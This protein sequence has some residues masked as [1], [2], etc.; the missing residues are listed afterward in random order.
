MHHA[1]AIIH[2][3]NRLNVYLGPPRPNV[4]VQLGGSDPVAMAT[5]ARIIADNGYHEVNIN[6]GCPSQRVQHGHFGAIL[7][8]TPDLVAEILSTI[9]V[10][11]PVTVKCRIGVDQLDSYEFFHGFVDTLLR[12]A[13]LPHLIVHARKCIL[14]GLSPKKNRSVPPLNYERVYQLA[15]AFPDLPISLN[16]GLDDIEKITMALARVDGCMIGRKDY[17]ETLLSQPL[18]PGL[19]PPPMSILV[20]PLMMLYGGRQGRLFRNEL[21]EIQKRSPSSNLRTIVL[22]ALTNAGIVH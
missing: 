7:M 9:K 6:V 18:A 4:V 12:N 8:K 19:R 16:G 20:K 11:I 13:S 21:F 22:G 15:E 2:N 1:Q 5:A 17:A 10:N 3:S 14:K